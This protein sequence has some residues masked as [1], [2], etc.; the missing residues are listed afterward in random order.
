VFVRLFFEVFAL[1]DALGVAFDPSLC[2][3][4]SLFPVDS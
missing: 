3:G 1:A 2:A 4:V